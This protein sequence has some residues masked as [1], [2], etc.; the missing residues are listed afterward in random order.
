MKKI[1][2]TSA[3]I[4][5]AT[6]G[7]NAQQLPLFSQYYYNPFLY[8][9]AFTGTGEQAN[10][11][12]IH[13]SQWKD[14]PG[15]PV[16]YALTVDGPVKDKQIGLGLSLFNDQ[17]DIFNRTGLYSSYSYRFKINSDHEITAGL[18]LG[19]ID[20]K[21]DYSRAIVTD[22]SDPLIYTD[23]RRKITL[24]ANFGVGYFWKDLR[25][26]FSVPQL[27]GNKLKYIEEDKN[28]YTLLKRHYILSGQY[29]IVV[30]D[31]N[32]IVALPSV[33]MRY[34]Q[35][36]PFQFDVNAAFEWKEMV[37]AGISYRFGYAVGFNIGT[38]L[39]K[40]LT[41]GYTYEWVTSPIGSVAGGGHE[42]MLGYSFGKK[43]DDDE[44]I[45]ELS[46][47]IENAQIQNDSLARTL[48]KKD[49]EHTD[50][51]EKL[52]QRMDSLNKAKST[53]EN[54]IDMRNEKAANHTDEEGKTI[55]P[56]Y[57]VIIESFKVK[58]NAIN[59]KKSYEGKG[60]YKP[61]LIYN[62]EREFYYV[63]VFFSNDQ[64]SA[65]DVMLMLQRERPD[66]WV[67]IME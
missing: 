26:G 55:V 22:A 8:N 27:L 43:R 35:G 7:A 2:Y 45:R 5:A 14:M 58:E 17:V 42:I 52:K 59:A 10:A 21:I 16:T 41:A 24:D 64:Q 51:I 39:N 36:T 23:N 1:I 25:V 40:N 9:P 53:G 4:V 47:A 49:Q 66:A 32:N 29:S 48:K 67:F 20:N 63:N 61:V 18:S 60:V 34:A 15:S 62:K 28:V 31:K 13:R 56:G 6:V 44:K 57:Y 46:D 30:S 19:V 33:M 12:L 65:E 3:L 50:E 54:K 38:K 37:R 11:F